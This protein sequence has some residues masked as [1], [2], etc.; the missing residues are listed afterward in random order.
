MASVF[1]IPLPCLTAIPWTEPSKN[2][3]ETALIELSVCELL[4]Q[5]ASTVAS[6]R[7]LGSG[8]VVNQMSVN[9][10]CLQMAFLLYS[11]Y[12]TLFYFV[13]SR[14]YWLYIWY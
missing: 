10:I 11:L 3:E 4:E 7:N 5:S 2:I 12:S 1:W 14:L 8:M 6:H 13:F 9:M